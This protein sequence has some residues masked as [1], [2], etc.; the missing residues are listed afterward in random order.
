MISHVQAEHAARSIRQPRV[1]AEREVS[2]GVRRL[3]ADIDLDDLQSWERSSYELVANP[4]SD[5]AVV[6]MSMAQP[7]LE[8][9]LYSA[10][11]I[12]A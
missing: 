1:N 10:T 9:W 2:R 6:A 8:P 12:T 7:L 11:P 3:G 5:A 4:P